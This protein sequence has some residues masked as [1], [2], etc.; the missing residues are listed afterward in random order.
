VPDSQMV[1]R[2]SDSVLTKLLE[3]ESELATQEASLLAQVEAIRQKRASLSAVVNMF[4]TSENAAPP[5]QPAPAAKRG[6]KPAQA[7]TQETDNSVS[8]SLIDNLIEIATAIPE[9]AAEPA[10]ETNG[11]APEPPA[12][13]PKAKRGRRAAQPNQ[14]KAKPAASTAKSKSPARGSKAKQ[15]PKEAA[16]EQPAPSS[17]PKSASKEGRKSNN[18]RNYMRPEFGKAPL[19]EV[20]SSV[21]QRQSNG[22]FDVPTI[23]ST[24]FVQDTPKEVR[25]QA[26]D[27]VLHILSAGVKEKKWYRGKTGQYSLSQSV[28]EST[29]ES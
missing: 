9:V 12:P 1:D 18:W 11:T 22:I 15:A 24:I 27:R 4:A 3:V 29:M 26:R 13:E 19:P 14:S 16:A 8:T 7:K 21:L 2:M 28:A 6:R 17:K 20:V 25:N 10:V 23:V 5:E